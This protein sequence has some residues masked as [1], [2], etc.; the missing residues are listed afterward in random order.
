MAFTQAYPKGDLEISVSALTNA[1]SDVVTAA[2]LAFAEGKG[3]R[4]LN[5][6]T[7]DKDTFRSTKV[8]ASSTAQ[9]ASLPSITYVASD[10]TVMPDAGKW[11]F[12]LS[13]DR[14]KL[15]FGPHCGLIILVR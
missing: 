4:I 14:R 11:H 5:A 13:T 6:D 7:L 3:V 12:R 8:I 2:S 10:G 9:I 15:K 1:T